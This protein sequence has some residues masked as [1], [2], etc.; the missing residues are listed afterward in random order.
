MVSASKSIFHAW[1]KLSLN[2]KILCKLE[3]TLSFSTST[4][5]V[6]QIRY[7]TSPMKHPFTSLSALASTVAAKS[8]CMR[9]DVCSTY[10]LSD[11]IVT[12]YIAVVGSS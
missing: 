2:P 4:T 5:F 12:Q 11:T 1:D 3:I 7:Y 10:H 6:C 9:P 8:G